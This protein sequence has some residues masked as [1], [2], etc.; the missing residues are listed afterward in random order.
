MKIKLKEKVSNSFKNNTT[1]YTELSLRKTLHRNLPILDNKEVTICNMKKKTKNDKIKI[2]FICQVPA[3][4]NNFQ[5]IYKA[6][7]DDAN[8]EAFILA[9]PEK[10]MGH[11]Y[12]EKYGKNKAYDMCSKFEENTINAQTSYNS[13]YS[14]E[15]INPDIVFYER[16][17]DI[18]L[19]EQYRSYNVK[20]YAKTCYVPYAYSIGN[21]NA[22]LTYNYEFLKNINYVFTENSYYKEM[23]NK[24]SKKFLNNKLKAMY[25]GYSRYSHKAI[26][27]TTNIS[28]KKVKTIL[29]LPR[30]TSDEKLCAT[31]FFQYKNFLINYC[32]SHKNVRLICRPHPLMLRNFIATGEM[33]EQEKEEFLE[34]FNTNK[35]LEYD[36]FWNHEISFKKAD[37]F[38]SDPTS[39]L[40]EELFTGKPVICCTNHYKFDKPAKRWSKFIYKISNK[41]ELQKQ[42]DLLIA[43]KDIN[44]EKRLNYLNNNFIFDKHT[45]TKI[46]EYL[47][48]EFY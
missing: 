13:W 37:I 22:K 31:T 23:L 9:L 16:P 24:I 17:Y 18:H 14:L 28:D 29:W 39:L 32:I 7:Q 20:K 42:L 47:K 35:N 30:W 33:T 48:K 27:L 34:I 4:W 12:E 8:I 15:N 25:F 26:G 41:N 44:K 38:V 45:E 1:Y 43:E 2:I 6:A 40:L 19:P 46:I 3:I 5:Y 36:D 11:I 21:F 10:I